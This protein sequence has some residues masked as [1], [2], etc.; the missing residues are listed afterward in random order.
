M[1]T[2]MTWTWRN[3]SLD[4]PHPTIGNGNES[5]IDDVENMEYYF[6][7]LS[8]YILNVKMPFLWMKHANVMG[9]IGRLHHLMLLIVCGCVDYVIVQSWYIYL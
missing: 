1:A 3:R 8:I 9:C 7:S 2:A 6:I 4:C 5:A